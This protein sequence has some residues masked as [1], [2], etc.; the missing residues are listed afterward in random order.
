[1]NKVN[2]KGID[3]LPFRSCGELAM[4]VDQHPGIL[5]AVNAEKILKATPLTQSIINRNIGYCDGAGPLM[6]LKSTLLHISSIIKHSIW[7]EPN[8]KSSKKRWRN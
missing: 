5:I 7:W 8:S 6:A 4:Y 1:M 3:I 2:I